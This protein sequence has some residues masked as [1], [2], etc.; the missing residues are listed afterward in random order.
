MRTIVIPD[1]HCNVQWVET[2]LKEQTYD[3]VVFLGDYFD[4]FHEQSWQTKETAHWLK[5]SIHQ[6]KR[7]HLFGNHDVWYAFPL[8]ERAICTGNTRDKSAIINGILKWEDWSRL[9]LYHKTQGWYCSHAG[10]QS[11]H[12]IHPI[13]GFTD[14]FLEDL[15]NRALVSAKAGVVLSVLRAGWSRGGSDPV[16]GITWA[17]FDSDK[18]IVNG[19][20]QIVGHTPHPKPVYNYIPNKRHPTATIVG[21]DTHCHH[22]GHIIDGDFQ[23]MANPMVE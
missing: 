6:P 23:V 20:K 5:H 14:E 9:R 11:N 15:C 22:L 18:K 2:F 19:I 21:L 3:E 17:D 10:L 13:T 7:V 12:F 1:L 16:G 4:C 8:A